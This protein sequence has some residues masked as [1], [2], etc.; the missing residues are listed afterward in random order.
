ME[1]WKKNLYV[2]WGTQFLAMMGMNL[3]VPFLPFFIRQLGITD[4]NELARW[5]GLV[6]SGPFFISFIATPIWGSMGDR[7]GRKLMVVR[8][9]FG[10]G[11]SQ[12]L[13]GLSQNVVQ[14]LL[15][16]MLQGAISGFI[17]AALTLVSTSTPK[18]RIGYALGVLQSST[19]AGVML[20]PAVGGF[21]ADM[22][23][24][25][26]IF[27][28]TA[29]LC[30]AAGAVI[31]RFVREVPQEAERTH[32][33]SVVQNFRMMLTDRQLRV[34]GI[35]IVLSQTSDLMI[36]PIFALFVESLKS[37]TKYVA[38]LAGVIFSITGVFM[39]ISAP[40]W[41][42]RNDRLG[43]RNNTFYALTGAGVA[44]ALHMLVPN[45]LLLGLVRAL[46]GF[47]RGGILHSLYSMTSLRVPADRRSGLM[48][49]AIS[50]SVLGN[51][52]GPLAGG[53]IAGNF[54]I[55]S[56]FAVNSVLLVGTGFLLWRFYTEPAPT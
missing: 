19:A 25:R 43:F 38:T 14:L 7:Y 49:I 5:S 52:I 47:A 18:E 23:G 1:P 46:L 36:E 9:I 17:A 35:A 32:Q 27:F 40:W 30:F 20:G 11:V 29:S 39:V 24:Y 8:A 21:L 48:G 51:M 4:Q 26:E 34:I 28:V 33:L 44:Y 12:A 31:I 53:M 10:L 16:R 37:D 55:A 45:L 15:F 41:G 6:F 56:V 22:M 54:G 2:L 50:L 42:N 3:V 13:I